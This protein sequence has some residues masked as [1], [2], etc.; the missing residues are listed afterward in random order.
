MTKPNTYR[1]VGSAALLA[2]ALLAA[3]AT[4]VQVDSQLGGN[5][6][7]TDMLV[8]QSPLAAE[9]R[10]ADIAG[11]NILELTPEM[12]SFIDDHIRDRTD[13]YERLR[14]LI[15]AVMGERNFH[16][17]YDESTRTA[18][19]TFLDRRGNC[20]SFTNMFIAMARYLGLEASYQEVDVPPD[21]S[22]SGQAFLLSKHVNLEVRTSY[23]DVQIID[24]NVYDFKIR[25]DRRII[26][27]RR[28]RAHYFNN[29]GAELMLSGDTPRALVH[30][31][32]SLIEDDEFSPAWINL[33]ILYRRE[34][35]P[36]YAEAAFRHVLEL[37]YR[38]L[39]AMSN[40][41]NLYEEQGHSETA[42]VY[43]ER[44]K[45]HR[46]ENPYFRYILANEA[47]VAGDY[48][49]AIQHL[50]YAIGKRRDE[51]RFMAL[52][53]M[54]HLMLG[55]RESSEKWMKRAEE[56][57]SKDADKRRYHHK[58][59]LLLSESGDRS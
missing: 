59:E 23:D 37:D 42:L 16:L 31:Q 56:A 29:L 54:S 36:A 46:M 6:V 21:W 1:V 5:E 41:A 19:E 11:V 17:E 3:C 14:L 4:P 30:F 55:D 18:S 24:F 44:V 25:H 45:N 26:S 57:A 15:F 35:Y 34:G 7:T 52:M 20:L 38:D 28:G 49:T 9:L 12:R 53:S 33:G 50:D 27:D 22:L 43:R 10:P 48:R 58:L 51:D 40:L 8:D 47:F 2:T 13:E 32:Q 39:V